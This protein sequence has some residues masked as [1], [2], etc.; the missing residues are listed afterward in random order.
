MAWASLEAARLLH[1]NMLK[2]MMRAPM[3]F[4]DTTPVGRIL[5][6]FSK[7]MYSVDESLPRTLGMFLSTVLNVIGAAFV[8]S[9]ATPYVSSSSPFC[10]F[11][12]FYR[13]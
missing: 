6:R 11:F 8:I 7:D 10:F 5:N 3:A 4:F 9:V 13:S 2:R 1:N 12:S